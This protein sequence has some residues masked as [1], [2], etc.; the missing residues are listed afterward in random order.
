MLLVVCESSGSLN[1]SKSVWTETAQVN[2][3][4]IFNL[5]TDILKH[6]AIDTLLSALSSTLHNNY[7]N[8]L[9]YTTLPFINS[10]TILYQM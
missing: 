3:F 4:L 2:I 9:Y 1:N 7:H 5:K 8:A 6:L 10:Y